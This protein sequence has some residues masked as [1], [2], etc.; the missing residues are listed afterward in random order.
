MNQL[1]NMRFIPIYFYQIELKNFCK[2]VSRQILYLD[3]IWIWWRFIYLLH[4]ILQFSF[5]SSQFKSVGWFV[6]FQDICWYQGLRRPLL[7]RVFT[8]IGMLSFMYCQ[9]SDG[10]WDLWWSLRFVEDLNKAWEVYLS[11][12]QQ[13]LESIRRWKCST[14]CSSWP[15]LQWELWKCIKE[16]EQVYDFKI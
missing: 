8:K 6:C 4:T 9:L 13:S 7:E 11:P 5:N 15:V 1:T 16:M 10:Y 12:C 14:P 2:D 3:L